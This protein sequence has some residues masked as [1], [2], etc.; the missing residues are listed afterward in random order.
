MSVEGPR[1]GGRPRPAARLG[2]SADV[3]VEL[4]ALQRDVHRLNEIVRESAGYLAETIPRVGTLEEHVARVRGQVRGLL[5]AGEHTTAEHTELRE[6]EA[7]LGLRPDPPGPWCWALLDAEQA[8]KAWHALTRW[9]ASVLVPTYAITRSE[10]V[11][12]WPRHPEIVAELSWL[13]QTYLEA[14]QRDAA[15]AE[16]MMWHLRCKPGALAAIRGA[17]RWIDLGGYQEPLCGPGHHLNPP[18]GS[19]TAAGAHAAHGLA[20]IEHWGATWREVMASDV[21]TRRPAPKDGPGED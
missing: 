20:S 6:A 9:V 12:C 17:I 15:A 4:A 14:H 5:A 10:L 2:G 21:A 1:S 18:S 13:R 19:P 3:A 7:A 11:D 16:N 8:E